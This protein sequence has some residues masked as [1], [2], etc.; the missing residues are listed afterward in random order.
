[1]LRTLRRRLMLSHMLPVLLIVPWLGIAF[2]CI[3]QPRSSAA[4]SSN[5]AFDGLQAILASLEY[6]L[7][8]VVGLG[9]LLGVLVG[10]R[11]GVEVGRP[12]GMLTQFIR[13]MKDE[14]TLRLHPVNGP[15][16]IRELSRAIYELAERRDE[17]ERER[18]KLLANLVHEF[19]RSLGA[20]STAVHACSH[21][22]WEEAEMR[23]NLL[24]GM[25]SELLGMKRLLDDLSHLRAQFIGDFKLRTR[26]LNLEQ[27]LSPALHLWQEVAEQKGLAWELDIPADLPRVDFD[28]DRL[29]QAL[30]NLIANAVKYTPPGG[31]VKILTRLSTNTVGIRVSDTGPGIPE[32]ELEQIFIPFYRGSPSGEPIEGMGLGLSIARDLV[33][34]HQGRLEVENNPEQGSHFTI[35]LPLSRGS[36]VPSNAIL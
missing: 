24:D 23:R 30:G 35:W 19:G 3:S 4:S 33:N 20:L 15:Q 29:N 32:E 27:W 26:G 25:E 31:K 9:L 36:S 13:S 12:L 11:L 1:M 7:A 10:W 21:G 18:R 28:P 8:M 14:Q 6:R 17:L 5:E 34:A 2:F 16:E 22:A